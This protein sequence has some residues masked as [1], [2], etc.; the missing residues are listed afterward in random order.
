MY[1]IENASQSIADKEVD[2]QL[3]YSIYGVLKGTNTR[4]VTLSFRKG[5]NPLE[6]LSRQWWDVVDG[7]ASG[8]GV[9]R[10]HLV[11]FGYTVCDPQR[12]KPHAHL[13][14]YSRKSQRNG[15]CWKVVSRKQIKEMA[16]VFRDN[17]GINL[18]VT[19]FF[20]LRGWLGYLAGEKNMLL[21]G[22]TVVRLPVWNEKILRSACNRVTVH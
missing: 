2:A 19:P 5:E 14:V 16:R 1:V 20:N 13:L 10:C 7:I 12:E 22:A 21:P 17:L 6:R 15:K 11:I 4:H 9:Q 18:E 8:I 3:R